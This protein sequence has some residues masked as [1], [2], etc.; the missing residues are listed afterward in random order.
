MICNSA[1]AVSDSLRDL[2]HTSQVAAFQL[3]D[4]T[5]QQA[6]LEHAR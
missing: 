4:T 5:A 2:S 6:M 1:I 3:G